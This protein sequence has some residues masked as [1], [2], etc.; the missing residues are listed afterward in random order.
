MRGDLHPSNDNDSNRELGLSSSA[1]AGAASHSRNFGKE[2]TSDL[3][4][5]LVP[6]GHKASLKRKVTQR[7]KFS[8]LNILHASKPAEASP[9]SLQASSTQH[10]YTVVSGERGICAH[11]CDVTVVSRIYQLGT[12]LSEAGVFTVSRTA[13]EHMHFWDFVRHILGRV[14]YGR[15]SIAIAPL[16][17]HCEYL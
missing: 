13:N 7:S 12:C 8:R 2:E 17:I 1:T 10:N 15:N 16:V 14:E 5:S 9:G 6:Q 3:H 4:P 11:M